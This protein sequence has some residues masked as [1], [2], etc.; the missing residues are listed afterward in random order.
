MFEH[1]YDARTKGNIQPRE[2]WLHEFMGLA[3]HAKRSDRLPAQETLKTLRSL[4]GSWLRSTYVLSL[5]TCPPDT[6]ISFEAAVAYYKMESGGDFGAFQK[7]KQILRG[8][9]FSQDTSGAYR[10]TEWLDSR[11]WLIPRPTNIK[12][13]CEEPEGLMFLRPISR[14]VHTSWTRLDALFETLTAMRKDAA[15]YGSH[16]DSG[17]ATLTR[18]NEVEKNIDREYVEINLLNPMNLIFGKNSPLMI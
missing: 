7:S 9:A 8:Y 4:F 1:M 11:R 3:P 18:A 14:N 6:R 12:G 5:D 15:I 16:R 13:F 17:G 10:H 2:D